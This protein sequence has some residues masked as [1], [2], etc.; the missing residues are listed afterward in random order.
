MSV[1]PLVE[2][3]VDA[4]IDAVDTEAPG[5]LS[6]LY[7]TGS[8]ALGDFRPQTSD[9]DFVAVTDAPPDSA[10]IAAL[11]RA[12]ARLRR[13][14]PSPYFDGI[15]V[16]WDDLASDPERAGFG[17][18]SHE[19]QFYAHRSSSDDPVTWHTLA[20]HGVACRGPSKFDVWADPEVLA[21]WTLDN[22]DTY[23]RRL[24][25]RASRPLSL[26]GLA[27]YSPYGAVWVVL[28]VTRLHY[29]LATGDI[30][31]KELAGCYALQVFPEEWHRIVNES[32][33][34][35]RADYA[36]PDVASLLA[37]VGDYLRFPREGGSLYRTPVAR[38]RDVLAF[39]DM[40]ITDAHRRYGRQAT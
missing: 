35:R 25:D 13:R 5:L 14:W 23:W 15:Y 24:L 32:L 7:L 18:Y 28:G 19:G 20:H 16:T 36:R 6:G 31:S 38:R 17:P 21:R 2:R 30:G 39:G 29:T 40:V 34:I 10:A 4:Y 9:I 12:H 27:A 1:H 22:L 3:T 8:A 33:R 26:W 37:E 11:E